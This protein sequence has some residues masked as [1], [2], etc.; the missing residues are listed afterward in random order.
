LLACRIASILVHVGWL[1]DHGGAAD[2][3]A[4]QY[5]DSANRGARQSL[6]ERFGRGP[7]AWHRWLFE[8]LHVS[9][10]EP[11][12]EIGCGPG[13]LWRKNEDR[14]PA[15]PAV[16]TDLSRGMV[17]EARQAL[18]AAAGFAF[19]TADIQHL[20]FRD[21]TFDI[22]TANHMLYHV[23]A[24]DGALSEVRRVLRPGGRFVAATNGLTHMQEVRAMLQQHLGIS[25]WGR[26]ATDFSLENGASALRK[27]F[28]HVELHR[29]PAADL[30][31]TE[32][33][34]LLDYIRSTG[35]FPGVPDR[36]WDGLAGEVS[37]VIEREGAFRIS[38]DPGAFVC[39]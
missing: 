36:A 14:P 22:V 29:P 9:E 30:L 32:V 16:L 8:L 28:S 3:V 1:E 31:V 25:G 19:A 33:A 35:P 15:M 7:D 13:Q 39:R 20:P 12:L 10:G 5:R 37:A 2:D 38:R 27:R 21:A 4:G 18:A 23:P 6:H 34:P 17:E 24:L 26:L 11:V